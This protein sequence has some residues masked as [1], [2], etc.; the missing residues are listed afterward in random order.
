MKYVLMAEDLEV[1]KFYF[2][3]QAGSSENRSIL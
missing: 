3:F 2:Y 1:V